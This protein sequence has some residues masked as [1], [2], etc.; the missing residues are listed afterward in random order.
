MQLI[1]CYTSIFVNMVTP[2]VTNHNELSILNK[3][4]IYTCEILY[5]TYST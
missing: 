3:Y 1:L 5:M 4:S 2:N